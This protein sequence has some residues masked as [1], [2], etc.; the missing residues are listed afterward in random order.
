MSLMLCSPQQ[1]I[2]VA[3]GKAGK[4]WLRCKVSRFDNSLRYFKLYASSPA[5]SAVA[6][7]DQ[8]P[9]PHPARFSKRQDLIVCCG[10]FVVHT[11]TRGAGTELLG[12][13]AAPVQLWCEDSE[14]ADPQLLVSMRNRPYYR[15]LPALQMLHCG[16][17][18][19][20]RP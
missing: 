8:T 12:R 13:L 10:Y 16:R 4:S 6:S 14:L 11:S 5:P 9:Q 7:F 2:Q 1:V 18:M 3:A 20:N 19:C 15:E 17:F